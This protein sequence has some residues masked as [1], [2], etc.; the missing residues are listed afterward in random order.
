MDSTTYLRMLRRRWRIVA[1]A[2]AL[3]IA[4]AWLVL[5][6]SRGSSGTFTATHVLYRPPGATPPDAVRLQTLALLAS[7]GDIPQRVTQRLGTQV[8]PAV[9]AAQIEAVGNDELGTLTIRSTQPVGEDAALLV[10]TFAEQILAWLRDRARVANEAETA[11][12]KARVDAQRT[13]IRQLDELLSILG[14]NAV[15]RPLVEAEH[16]ALI[17]QYGQVL[18][19]LDQ[20]E[21]AGEDTSGVVT[22]QAGVPV[23]TAQQGFQPPRSRPVLVVVGALLGLALGVVLVLV[24]ERFDTKVRTRQGAE[25]AFGLPVVAEVPRLRLPQSGTPSV[26]TADDPTSEF[27]E[28]YRRL[29]QGIQ[30]MPRWVLP[31]P[32]PS[33]MVAEPQPAA[34]SMAVPA[35]TTPGK[36]QVILV[37]SPA[38]GEGKT[39]TVLNLAASFA[40]VGSTVLVIDCDYRN[41]QL[42]QYLSMD[43][44]P[45]LSDLLTLSRHTR[46]PK[47]ESFVKQTSLPGVSLL[48]G[49]TPSRSPSEFAGLDQDLLTC[50]SGLAEVIILDTGPILAVNDTA[51]LLPHVEAVVVVARSGHTSAEAA[52]RTTQLLAR[53]EA[54]ILGITLVD[55]P[56]NALDGAYSSPGPPPDAAAR[57]KTKTS[58]NGH[59]AMGWIPDQS[60]RR[61]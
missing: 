45:G 32:P 57:A 26:L 48:A 33:G 30:L 40:E 16:Q 35:R 10:N 23:P 38:A 37:T 4:A 34:T 22:L 14:E 53:L 51:A 58:E 7:A 60:A 39:T 3:A 19:Q 28:A 18:D 6:A 12:A 15:E 55:V 1:L 42:H 59:G 50:T 11:E 27:A 17:G 31:P 8:P 21:S 49:G 46:A 52:G 24:L 29:R 44:G 13:R 25:A 36:A 9:V 5:P 54:R 47:A 56:R 20:L 61:R 41:P 2:V 43:Q